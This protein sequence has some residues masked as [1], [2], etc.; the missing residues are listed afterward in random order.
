MPARGEF[1]RALLALDVDAL[2]PDAI[3]AAAR[4]AE[5]LELDLVGLFALDD[6][7]RELAGYPS[8]REF[9]PVGRTWRQIDLE[10]IGHEQQLAAQTAQ[11]MFN[12][13]AS[14]M[15]V[16]STFEVVPGP[17]TRI[18]ASMSRPSDILVVAEPR[19]ASA[20]V[21]R[22]F[23]LLF[24]VAI[25][26][27]ASVLVVPRSVRRRRGPIVGIAGAP[28]DP[29][30]QVASAIAAAAHEEL[31]VIDAHQASQTG[32]GP[33]AI[34]E[35]ARPSRSIHEGGGLLTDMRNLAAL[36]EN[37]DESLIVLTREGFPTATDNI[38][39][40]IAESRRVPVLILEPP[41]RS[42]AP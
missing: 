37:R 5:L 32:S 36:L 16:P 20:C 30:M 7:L 6:T 14:A 19:R 33:A 41:R 25:R 39:M 35:T 21:T 40:L 10:R 13:L 18:L 38:G 1:K 9:V 17:A 24:D 22:S 8:A 11:R 2:D 23:A 34:I 12:E 42:T 26:S 15:R 28:D 27:T 3:D 31:I 29:G 4:L